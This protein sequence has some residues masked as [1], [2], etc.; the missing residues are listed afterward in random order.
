MKRL[1]LLIVAA[2]LALAGAACSSD[3]GTG[4]A[5]G[6]DAPSANTFEYAVGGR[7]IEL[8]DASRPT[9]ADPKRNLPAR[10]NRRIAVTLLYPA[11]GNSIPNRYLSWTPRL[12]K[13]G[14]RS[15]CSR[16]AGP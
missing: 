6:R 9:A 7:G 15:W 5:T 14:S 11:T 13:E 3:A 4:A 8:V 1:R 12:P 16:M 2:A 10:P